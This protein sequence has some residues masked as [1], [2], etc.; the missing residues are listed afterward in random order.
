LVAKALSRGT[1]KGGQAQAGTGERMY[2]VITWDYKR[3]RASGRVGV[4]KKRDLMS[5][6]IEL[7]VRCLC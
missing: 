4:K 1:R 5:K 2:E 3:K 6:T 7:C